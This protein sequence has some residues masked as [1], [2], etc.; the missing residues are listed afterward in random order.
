MIK[1]EHLRDAIICKKEDSVLEVAKILRDTGSRFLIVVNYTQEPIGII[2]TT[3]IVNRCI[4][5]EDDYKEKKAAD[6]MTKDIET[7]ELTAPFEEIIEDLDKIQS[8]SLPVTKEGKVVGIIDMCKIVQ[9]A[10]EHSKGD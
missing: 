9:L 3:D 6:I 1:P 4:A 8:H 5:C 2:S 10:M 7:V